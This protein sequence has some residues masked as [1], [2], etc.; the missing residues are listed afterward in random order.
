M[1]RWSRPSV[2][3]SVAL[4]TLS[5]TATAQEGP[6]VT[7]DG[8]SASGA[9]AANVTSG[10]ANQQANVGT[11]G[12]GARSMA[13]GSVSQNLAAPELGHTPS[14]RAAVED[15]AFAGSAGWLAANLSA[16]AG[17]Q[18]ANVAAISVGLGGS[19]LT[20]AMLSQSRAS[21][22]ENLD[23]QARATAPD[24]FQAHIGDGAFAGSSGL[25]Q[26]N[27]AAGDGNTSGNVFVLAVP[28][29]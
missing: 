21:T 24:R 2:L 4:I 27:L 12:V 28:E 18:Q 17:N 22:L 6:E 8:G 26:I 20:M 9:I 23:E 3:L 5:S 15:G 29:Q 13:L 25:I 7:L 1:T 10:S 16:G 11:L 19:P 14:A